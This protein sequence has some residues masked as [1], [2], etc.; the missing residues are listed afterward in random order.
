MKRAS[1]VTTMRVCRKFKKHPVGLWDDKTKSA[2]CATCGLPLPP[3]KQKAKR[4]DR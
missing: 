3:Q 2:K 1:K 4:H